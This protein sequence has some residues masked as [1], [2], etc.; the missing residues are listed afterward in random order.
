[1]VMPRCE[2]DRSKLIPEPHL[3]SVEAR[4]VIEE[5]ANELREIMKRL[6]RLLN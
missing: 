3:S 6:R 5:D 4:Q 1:M 2:M